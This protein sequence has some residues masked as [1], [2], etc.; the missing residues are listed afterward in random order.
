M[1]FLLFTSEAGAPVDVVSRL[2]LVQF[3]SMLAAAKVTSGSL[4]HEQLDELFLAVQAAPGGLARCAAT[5]VPG[6]HHTVMAPGI[7]APVRAAA[8]AA[9]TAGGARRRSTPAVLTFQPS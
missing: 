9:A 1:L 6:R 5:S 7:N 2:S 4:P 3:K 8:A